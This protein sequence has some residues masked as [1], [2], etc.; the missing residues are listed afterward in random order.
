MIVGVKALFLGHLR[1]DFYVLV[2]NRG[3]KIF[4]DKLKTWLSKKNSCLAVGIII[5]D[6][7]AILIN[8]F[9]HYSTSVAIKKQFFLLND[10]LH[11]L[12]YKYLLR[13]YSSSP[14]THSYIKTQ[15]EFRCKFAAKNKFL[16]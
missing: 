12:F 13:K 5:S 8:L 7:N 15:L 14:K 11:K 3:I 1:R 6:L 16:L 9:K 10:L 2:Q 4:K